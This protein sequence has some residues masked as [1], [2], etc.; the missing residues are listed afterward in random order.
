MVSTPEQKKSESFASEYIDFHFDWNVCNLQ[1]TRLKM[2]KLT[3]D[4]AMFTLILNLV[5]FNC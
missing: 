3:Y 1:L 5:E 2:S 4:E